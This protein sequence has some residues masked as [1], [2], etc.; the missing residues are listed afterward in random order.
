MK[1][2]FIGLGAMGGPMAGHLIDA[3][4][5]LTVLTR[6]RETAAAT[7]AKGAVWGETPRQLAENSEIVFTVLPAPKDIVATMEGPDGLKAGFRPGTIYVDLSTNAPS[8]VRQLFA[9][10]AEIGVS[11]LD[12]PISGGPKG[13]V[14]RKLAIWVGGE[15]S[16]FDRCKPVLEQMGDQTRYLGGSGSGSIA[17]LVH[18]CANYGIQM[19]LAECFTLGVKAG[20]DPATLF[21]AIR[22]GS[23][24]RQRAVDRMA[25]QFLPHV[26]DQPTFILELAHKDISL[27]TALGRETNVPMRIGNMTLAEMTEGLNKGWGKLDSRA[28]MLVQTER[29]GVDIRVPRDVL[30]DILKNEPL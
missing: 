13:A 29:S 20:V 17:K 10:L 12:A 24:G 6:S 8:L 2:G 4:H 5:E 19:V 1:I 28:A 3:G 7:L 25:D 23:L 26:F 27:A 11:M 18:N 15:Q 9:E 30:Q 22:Q 16:T 21:G 14:S